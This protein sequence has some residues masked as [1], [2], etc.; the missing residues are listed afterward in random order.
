[1]RVQV[2]GNSEPG[3][4]ETKRRET[5]PLSPDATIEPFR[6]HVLAPMQRYPWIIPVC[7]QGL[8][9]LAFATK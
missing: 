1:M 4:A 7:P 5:Q 6:V 3:L 2:L 8:L 9:P